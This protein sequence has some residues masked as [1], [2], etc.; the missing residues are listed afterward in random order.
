MLTY[1]VDTQFGM[2]RCDEKLWSTDCSRVD[3]ANFDTL[4]LEL[5]YLPRNVTLGHY[6]VSSLWIC[7]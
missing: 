7:F 1:G 2:F 4:A 3:N 5:Y 6:V